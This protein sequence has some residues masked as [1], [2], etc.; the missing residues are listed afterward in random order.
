MSMKVTIDVR[1]IGKRYRLRGLHGSYRNFRESLVRAI[2]RPLSKTARDPSGDYFWALRNATFEVREGEVLGLI[3]RNGAGKST[4][5]KILSR[6]TTP[7]EGSARLHGRTG[8]LL[9]VGT[10]FHPELTGRENIFLSGTVL[11]MRR[12]E[13]AAKLEEIVAFSELEKFL[14]TPVKHYSSG[15]YVR[16]AFAVA[17]HLEPEI[18]FIDEVLAVGDVNFQKKCLGKM[19]EVARGGRTVVFVSHNMGAIQRLCHRCLLLEEGRIVA[20]GTPEEVTAGYLGAFTESKMSWSRR[21]T[22]EADAFFT[23]IAVVDENGLNLSHVLTSTSVGLDIQYRIRR[24]N[25]RLCL[26]VGLLDQYGDQIFGSEPDDVGQALPKEPGDY[27]WRFSFPPEL[28][29]PR[30]YRLAVVLWSLSDGS[31]DRVEGL[32]F[33][34]EPGDSFGVR[35]PAGRP[36]H[37]AVRCGWE[38]HPVASFSGPSDDSEPAP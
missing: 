14:D 31:I 25:R 18:L 22:S 6:I 1:G 8:S 28:L 17:A 33:T 3:G 32:G 37:I 9:E 13:I 16:L 15:M 36:G 23:R 34:A 12:A 19:G 27:R 7:T 21:E 24:L 10:G 2:T 20:D 29:M 5:L 26:S 30:T 38:R 35:N 4:L 11:G